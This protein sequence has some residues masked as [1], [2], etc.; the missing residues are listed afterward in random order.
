[1]VTPKPLPRIHWDVRIATLTVG[2][3]ATPVFWTKKVCDC[4]G[5]RVKGHVTH[6]QRWCDSTTNSGAEWSQ[7]NS[8]VGKQQM[9]CFRWGFFK[10]L[11]I[12]CSN[13]L[14]KSRRLLLK[15]SEIP[16]QVE[17]ILYTIIRNGC[18]LALKSSCVKAKESTMRE[19]LHKRKE[20]ETSLFR[21]LPETWWQIVTRV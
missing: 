16:V 19:V 13:S 15:Y 17:I 21:N 5:G 12:S 1:M 9:Y 20:S 4:Q 3:L 11:L 6:L 2:I 7:A 14:Q 8:Q 10:G 18:V